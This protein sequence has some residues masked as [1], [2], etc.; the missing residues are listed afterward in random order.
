MELD[1]APKVIP[2][3]FGER[4]VLV[5]NGNLPSMLA[6]AD[7]LRLYGDRLA[8]V[9]VTY[10]LPSS[11]S[12]IR[13][14]ISL[15]RNSGG[16]YLWMKLLLNKALPIELKLKGHPS[17]VMDYI[18]K[19]GLEIP[20][21]F[22]E[23]VK[24]PSFLRELKELEPR[25]LVSFSATQRFPKQMVDLFPD[26]AVNVHYG[27]LPRFAGLSPY[28]WHLYQQEESFGVTLHRIEEALDAGSVIEQTIAPVLPTTDC[29]DLLLSMSER[30]SPML[31]RLFSGETSIADAR[32]QSQE[33]RTYFGHPTRQ[34]VK[35]FHSMGFSMTSRESIRRLKSEVV[36]KSIEATNCAER[37][38]ARH[39]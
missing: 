19:L 23:S 32:A 29:I 31:I 26:G 7:W 39:A 33:H 3:T 37:E 12:N 11:K 27:A 6:L 22:V 38:S 21:S 14:A 9:Y 36:K 13:G 30:V 20:V 17:S 35:Q 24:K 28:F 25:T 16:S 18:R 15:A 2:G 1:S 5:T 4:C 10:K 8:K 34:Q